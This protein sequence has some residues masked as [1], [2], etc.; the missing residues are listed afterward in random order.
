MEE[1]YMY[2]IGSKK[3]KEKKKPSIHAISGRKKV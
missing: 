3:K 2:G 1:L